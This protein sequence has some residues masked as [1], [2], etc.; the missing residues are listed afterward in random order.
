MT[1]KQAAWIEELINDGKAT[2]EVKL[3]DNKV[4]A[5]ITNLQGDTQLKAE[6]KMKSID[7][8]PAFV[9]HTYSVLILSQVLKG[10]AIAKKKLD[11]KNTDEAYAFIVTLPTGIIDA[12]VK[13]HSNFEKELAK[14]IT[15]DDVVEN[16]TTPP[17]TA[18]ALKVN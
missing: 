18:S 16:F 12:L 2:T 1:E 14:L 15:G 11:F 10:Y 9:V 13:A 7:G 8:T 6:E 4:T 3:L 5:L 17:E